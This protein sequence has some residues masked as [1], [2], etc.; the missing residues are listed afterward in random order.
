MVLP[1]LGFLFAPP[2]PCRGLAEEAA[3][4]VSGPE[5]V[6]EAAS[7]AAPLVLSL[8][9][10]PPV[11]KSGARSEASESA[12]RR[13][14][15]LNL[16]EDAAATALADPMKPTSPKKAPSR[17]MWPVCCSSPLG[18]LI[19]SRLSFFLPFDPRLR[20]F[21]WKVDPPEPPWWNSSF[22]HLEW[23]DEVGS[24]PRYATVLAGL[25]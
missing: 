21:L 16:S 20:E 24:V 1:I 6:K 11:D 25:K 23:C 3:G 10:P 4:A 18:P 22:C 19:M 12:R 17:P 5:A 13:L 8:A 7:G 2:E 14:A 9:A 15:D